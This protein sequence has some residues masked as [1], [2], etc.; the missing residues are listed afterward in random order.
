MG[1][2]V[3]SYPRDVAIRNLQMKHAGEVREINDNISALKREFE[4]NG[5]TRE[6]FEALVADQIGKRQKLDRELAEKVA[7]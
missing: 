4:R 6:R 3:S 7:P 2:K 1:V 5:L